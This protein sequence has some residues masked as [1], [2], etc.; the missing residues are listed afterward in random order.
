MAGHGVAEPANVRYDQEEGALQRVLDGAGICTWDWDMEKGEVTWSDRCMGLLGLPDDAVPDFGE[1][2]GSVHPDDRADLDEA[3]RKARDTAGDHEIEIRTIWPD[4]AVHWITCAA[5]AF[6]DSTGKPRRI[7]GVARDS[8]AYKRAEAAS[9]LNERRLRAFIEHTP[10]AIA[11]FDRSMR[12][13]TVS[14]RWLS[15][16]GLG[17]KDIVGLSHYEV[18]PEI[19]DGW[20]EMHRRC[21]AGETISSEE[22]PFPRFDGKTD[23]VRWELMPW[24]EPSGEIGGMIMFTEVVTARKLAEEALRKAYDEMEQKVRDRTEELRRAYEKLREESEERRKAE[25]NLRQMAA[26]TENAAEAIVITD[27]DFAISYANPAFSE[28]TGYASRELVGK[29]MAV[30][31]IGHKQKMIEQ[32]ICVPLTPD[33]KL[34]GIYPILARDG[35]V[36]CGRAHIS[37][38]K[39]PSGA[40]QHYVIVIDDI[41]EQLRLEEQLRQ[42]QKM[43]AVG[44]LAGG[45]AH[46]FNNILAIILGNAELILDEAAETGQ[47]GNIE[48]IVLAAGR[49]RELIKQILAFSRKTTPARKAFCLRTLVEETCALLRASLPSTI[50]IRFHIE[51]GPADTILGDQTQIQQVVINLITNAAQATG[52]EGG[53]ITVVL[54]SVVVRPDM[55]LPGSGLRPGNYVGLAVRDTGVGMTE[56][57]RKRIFEPFFT[58]KVVGQGSGMGLSV[59][60]GIVKAHGGEISVESEKGHGSV[61]HVFLPAS[62]VPQ[63]R[64][65]ERPSSLPTGHEQILLV[66]DE[67]PVVRMA[68]SALARLGYVVTGVT[69]S[70]RALEVFRADPKRFDLMI[71][72]QTMPDLTGIALARNM[73]EVRKDFPVVL[74][75]GHC[76][77]VTPETAREAG[78]R[79]FVLKPLTRRELAETI[80]RALDRK[81]S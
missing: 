29:N 27:R 51:G 1:F 25:E 38:I 44:T 66:D 33:R 74:M 14:R 43:E 67:E 73:M 72:D 64:A 19:S 79:E 28:I 9:S 15:D 18:F 62:E 55:V 31:G 37:A 6:C 26:A 17:N 20:K 59:A 75:T 68:E 40:P 7:A 65:E 5:H 58:T 48:Q 56:D 77:A 46:D 50:D 45:I 21:L 76:D 54:S 60:Y 23:W 69:N 10:A 16:Y 12:Y 71:A 34:G 81:P 3:I 61:F 70:A 53:Q 80:R 24:Y 42:A 2:M 39:G 47:S 35:R 8:T 63:D 4:R 11:V 36:K 52:E 57:V 32:G 41:T 78:I 49:G 22:E 30:L 13:V